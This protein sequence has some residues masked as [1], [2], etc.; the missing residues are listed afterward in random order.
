MAESESTF[1]YKEFTIC[2][3]IL[4][5]LLLPDGK[6][7]CSKLREKHERLGA[8][9]RDGV[10]KDDPGILRF[11]RVWQCAVAGKNSPKIKKKS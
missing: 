6:V 5:V 2:I 9:L 4:I 10:R 8:A 3:Y 1:S 7:L 11:L